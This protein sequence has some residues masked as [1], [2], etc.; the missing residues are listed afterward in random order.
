MK[1]VTMEDSTATG[2]VN[3]LEE[4]LLVSQNQNG[5]LK[6]LPF[7]LANWAFET[8]A[9]CAL[10][11]DM[12]LYLMGA[13]GL[14]LS[15]GTK[16]VFIF[17]TATSTMQF[18]GAILSDSLFGRFPMIAFGSIS[19]LVGTILLWLTTMLPDLRPQP[20]DISN[21]TKTCE[22][23]TFY[24]LSVICSSLLLI[25]VGR[26]GIESSSLAF[27][28]DQLYSK[29]HNSERASLSF[30]KYISRYF[31]VNLPAVIVGGTV[32]VYVQ[33]QLGWKLGYKIS[34]ILLLFAVLSIFVASPLYVKLKARKGMF[35]EL[36]GV[37]VVSFKHRNLKLPSEDMDGFYN[38]KEESPLTIPSNK[39]RSSGGSKG[40]DQI[41]PIL[42]T[43]FILYS[44]FSQGSIEVILVKTMDRH[45]TPNFEIPAGAFGFVGPLFAMAWL[46]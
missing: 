20:C 9:Y 34:V 32:V 4:R 35:S 13:Y 39:L 21:S 40:I 18:F 27:G 30:D 37:I 43:S 11:A 23:A 42:S 1:L 33:E 10:M 8:S 17:S 12:I 15:M 38:A 22:A 19:I 7:I 31:Q 24:Q 29:I 45:I 3:M 26:G 6:T 36:A 41:S 16:I 25:S 14:P 46:V 28:A 44:T 2:Q 5:G